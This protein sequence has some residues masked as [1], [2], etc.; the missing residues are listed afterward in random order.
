[1]LGIVQDEAALRPNRTTKQDRLFCRYLVTVGQLKLLKQ[2]AEF[3][4]QW[5]VDNNAESAFFVVFT[6]QG[7]GA[8]EIGVVHARHGDEQLIG[9]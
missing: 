9:Q 2:P 6:N 5:P 7:D 1:M 4:A 8:A 3:H